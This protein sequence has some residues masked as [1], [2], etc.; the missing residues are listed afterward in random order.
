M[1]SNKILLTTFMTV[2]LLALSADEIDGLYIWRKGTFRSFALTDILFNKNKV[3]IGDATINVNNIDSITFAKLEEHAV[4]TDTVY[5]SYDGT[6]ATVTPQNME[7][8]TT[9]IDGASVTLTNHNTD[10]EMTFVLSGESAEGSFIYDGNYKACIRLAGV[11]L[12]SRT[13]A[14]VHI[15]CGKR[16]GLELADGTTNSLS[17]ATTD[18]GQKAALYCKGHLE[19]SGG[20]ELSVKGNVRHAISTKEY[21]LVKKTTGIINVTG[22][23][24]DGIHAGQYFKMSGGAINI[25]GTK[26]DG[27]HAEATQEDDENNG[28]II[29]RGGIVNIEIAERNVS[30][31]KSDSLMSISG[32]TLTINTTGDGDKGLKSKAG[33]SI[34]GGEMT[35][36][37]NGKYIVEDN[38]PGYVTSIKA[39][40]NLTVSGGTVTINNTGEAGKGFSADGNINISEKDAT[41]IMNINTLGDGGVLNLSRDEMDSSDTDANDNMDVEGNV[42]RICAALSNYKGRYWNDVVYLCSSD[43]TKIARM[44]KTVTVE[45]SGQPALTFFYYDFDKPQSGQFFFASNDYNSSG[46]IYRLCTPEVSGPTESTPI[47]YYYI[48]TE[49]YTLSGSDRIFSVVD[50]TMSYA[51][52]TV[53]HMDSIAYDRV[54]VTAAG[55]KGDSSINIDGGTIIINTIGAAA[56]GITCD[57]TLTMTGGTIRIQSSGTGLGFIKNTVT[58]KGMASDA[59]IDLQGGDINIQMTGDG[60]KGIK[61]GGTLIIGKEGGEGPILNINLSGAKYNSSSS[62]KAIKVSG[63]ITVNGGESIIITSNKLAEGMESKLRSDA[64]VIINGGKHYFKCYDDC[65]NTEGGIKF[66]G[67]IVVAYSIINDAIDSNYGRP[68]AV[69]IGD[70]AVFA[71]TP[72]KLDGGIDCDNASYIQIKGSGIAICCGGNP[73]HSDPLDCIGSAVQGYYFDTS[74]ISYRTGRY[75][76]LA[77]ADGNNLATYS[78]EANFNSS[79]SFFT[80][81]GMKKGSTYTVKYSTTKPTD[82]TTEWHGFHLGSS[83]TGS[84]QSTSFT[85]Q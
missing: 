64:S 41:L 42:Y 58:A 51:D 7:G 77:D 37:Q 47:V 4:A 1:K 56:K 54:Y 14:A 39:N 21:M 78:F 22:A 40:N 70:G 26:G 79:L 6:F 18:L 81:T 66:D 52:A 32:G 73:F 43:G 5:I 69:I 27:I 16:I 2:G 85:A 67:G 38:N 55:I 30:A 48:K 28:Q 3:S 24:G 50:Y 31:I 29:I 72:G 12:Q 75:Y 60:S 23:D 25:S 9:S 20:G 57:K 46:T 34:V 49:P 33:I 61:S 74:P 80:A 62:A 13:G 44:T 17:D 63:A 15:K 8:I 19:V 36:T 35:F 10:R 59:C 53:L 68:G 11:S 71:Y 65:I 83:A 82:A 84:I 45:A 76:T